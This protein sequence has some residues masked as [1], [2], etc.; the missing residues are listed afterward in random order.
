MVNMTAKKQTKSP[1]KVT[2]S[3]NTRGQAKSTAE[4]KKFSGNSPS[5][6]IT[7]PP[8]DGL[9]GAPRVFPRTHVANTAFGVHNPVTTPSPWNFGITS[10][11]A[12]GRFFGGGSTT[13]RPQENSNSL[14]SEMFTPNLTPA[15]TTSASTSGWF[16]APQVYPNPA[17]ITPF[18]VHNHPIAPPFNI[19][20]PPA[21]F[22]GLFGGGSA[23]PS[24][25]YFAP[26]STPGTSSSGLFGGSNS[27]P[28]IFGN[29]AVPVP[30]GLFGGGS[31]IT[32]LF[33]R[34]QGNSNL[35]STPTRTTSTSTSGYDFNQTRPFHF[36]ASPAP[37]S[38][39]FKFSKPKKL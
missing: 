18:G 33:A 5:P 24:V 4:V 38:A 27:A 25:V 29:T 16:G 9:F 21:A 7:S 39:P 1:K 23:T 11:P 35:S 28:F 6:S 15:R 20:E 14:F 30:S 2:Q 37:T 22:G 17:T 34:P 32:S 26:N 10:T 19:G 8:S 36:G 31:A 12:P 3:P 13:A